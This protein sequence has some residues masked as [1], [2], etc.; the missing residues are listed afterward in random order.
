MFVEPNH[1]E[2]ELHRNVSA[3]QLAADFKLLRA[4]LKESPEFSDKFPK[5]IIVGP[6]TTGDFATM[7]YLWQYVSL[8]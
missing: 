2:Q 1:F 6:S 3:A 5:S 8:L 4:M 7:N